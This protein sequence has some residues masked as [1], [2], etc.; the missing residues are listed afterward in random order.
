MT[1]TILPTRS[2]LFPKKLFFIRKLCLIFLRRFKNEKK[3]LIF[4][5]NIKKVNDLKTNFHKNNFI[6]DKKTGYLACEF[7]KF[8]FLFQKLICFFSDYGTIQM[9]QFKSFLNIQGKIYKNVF[10]RKKKVFILSRILKN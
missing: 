6:K 10:A 5:K 8:S 1:L 2:N 3:I 4:E 9:R 7:I